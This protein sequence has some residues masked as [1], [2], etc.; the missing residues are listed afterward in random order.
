M[1]P[2]WLTICGLAAVFAVN[3]T[4]AVESESL[5]ADAVEKKERAVARA[6]LEQ[7]VDVNARQADRMTALHWAVYHD[8]LETAKLLVAADAD[9]TAENRYG[10]PPLSIACK[11]GNTAIVELL[12][13]ADADPNSTLR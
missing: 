3:S 1:K 12:L 10:V 7:R 13:A 11:S 2:Q 6:L 9:V 5:L 4:S 8:D